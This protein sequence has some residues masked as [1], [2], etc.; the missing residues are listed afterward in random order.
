MG[1]AFKC[2]LVPDEL[3]LDARRAVYSTKHMGVGVLSYAPGLG[4]VIPHEF[5]DQ[6]KAVAQ[7]K[8]KQLRDMLKRWQKVKSSHLPRPYTPDQDACK[9]WDSSLSVALSRGCAL[10]CDDLALRRAAESEGI[11]T[12][13]TWALYEVLASTE[14]GHGSQHQRI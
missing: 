7:A 4:R 12:F 1:E 9:S 8:A 6:Q 11:T 10:W 14:S 5:S 3:V 13:G 2:V